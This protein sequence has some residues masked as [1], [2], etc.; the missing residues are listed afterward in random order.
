MNGLKHWTIDLSHSEITFR[1][2][3][4]MIA[5]VK[6]K[7]NFFDA[8]IQT[9]SRDF[10]TA[11]IELTIDAASID[12]G[13]TIRDKH[14]RSSDF[15]DIENYPNIYFVSTGLKK[16]SENEDLELSGKLTI[17][18]ISKPIQLHI[19]QGGIANDLSGHEKA[20]FLIKGKIKR[21]EWGLNWNSK[22][23]T[24]GF[25]VSDEVTITCDIELLNISEH[26]SGEIHESN[27]HVSTN[28]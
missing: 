16:S 2:I 25:L 6:G 27:T 5:R 18:G 12:T 20:G 4:L 10:S 14:L 11:K 7:F 24:G 21:S 22:I 8:S 17:K 23:E 9:G 26:K 19:Q 28:T 15:F 3:H 13:E 1:V